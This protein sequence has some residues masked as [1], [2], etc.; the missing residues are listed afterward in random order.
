MPKWKECTF[1]RHAKVSHPSGKLYGTM[2]VPLDP[3]GTSP[4]EVALLRNSLPTNA[5]WFCSDLSRCVETVRLIGDICVDEV[6]Y[7]P[8]L[9]EQDYGRWE[10]ESR[11]VIARHFKKPYWILPREIRPPSGESFDDLCVR[12]LRFLETLCKNRADT[13]VAITHGNFIRAIMAITL[14]LEGDAPSKV[15]VRP[16]GAITVRMQIVDNV[17]FRELLIK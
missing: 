17:L 1:V 6:D 16:L 13:F 15:E 9:R 8:M 10:G 4:H 5:H 3:N 7:T 11:S 14:S 12:A 2:N